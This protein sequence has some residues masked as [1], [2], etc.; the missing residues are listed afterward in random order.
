MEAIDSAVRIVLK[1]PG[2]AQ[3]DHTHAALESLRSPLPR[4]FVRRS[5]KEQLHATFAQL[6][7][8]K[9]M[10]A[11]LP[12]PEHVGVVIGEIGGSVGL[13]GKEQWLR[14]TRMSA[15]KTRKFKAGVAGRANDRSLELRAH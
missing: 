3:V 12:V 5:E 7:P 6:A 9:R 2:A 14:Q 15:E 4:G 10:H 1:P 11:Q 13:A 8:I